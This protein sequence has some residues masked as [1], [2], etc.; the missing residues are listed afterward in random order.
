MLYL[1]RG[2][3]RNQLTGIKFLAGGF[4]MSLD[5]ALISDILAFACTFL[6]APS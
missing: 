2:V 5:F 3:R 6:A 1:P 4:N